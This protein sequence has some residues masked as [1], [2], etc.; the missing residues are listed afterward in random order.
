MILIDM[1]MPESCELCPFYRDE[2]TEQC[3]LENPEDVYWA[4]ESEIKFED[5]NFE[6]PLK[7]LP[8]NHGRLIDADAFAKRFEPDRGRLIYGDN[9]I[10]DLEN[11]APTIIEA[12]KEGE[13]EK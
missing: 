9:F 13:W 3:W 1:E 5:R 4:V 6:C 10:F 7:E 2:P 11:N 8:K 12:D